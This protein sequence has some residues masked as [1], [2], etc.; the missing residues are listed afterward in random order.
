MGRRRRNP[1]PIKLWLTIGVGAAAAIG[2]GYVAYR[3]VTGR[4]RKAVTPPLARPSLGAGGC[5]SGFFFDGKRCMPVETPDLFQ[6]AGIYVQQ[7]QDFVFVP[8]DSGPQLD[9]LQAMVEV[10]AEESAPDE[11]LSADP[12]VLATDF[13]SEF[14]GECQWPPAPNAPQR[15]VQLY[16]AL[17]YVIG[18]EIVAAGGRVLG[19]SDPDLVDEQIAERLASLGFFD[20]NPD[21]V[22]EI[23]L[24]SA[25]GQE[26]TEETD[27]AEIP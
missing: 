14:W 2:G 12:T 25:Y 24:P 3:V 1:T 18:R 9:F 13:F 10:E 22:P 27:Q 21:I 5:P 26:V 20:F 8:G 23:E 19:T 15:L 7:C 4:R 11:A 6:P 16:V 17:S